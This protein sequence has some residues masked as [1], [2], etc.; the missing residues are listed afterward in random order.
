MINSRFTLTRFSSSFSN[1]RNTEAGKCI[2]SIGLPCLLGKL[3]DNPQ[4]ASWFSFLWSSSLS[5]FISNRMALLA[6]L[7]KLGGSLLAGSSCSLSPW[8]CGTSSSI[9]K[10]LLTGWIELTEASSASSPSCSLSSWKLISRNLS[11][12]ILNRLLVSLEH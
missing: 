2:H 10:A 5:H 12:Y 3:V 1:R 11:S 8:S 7:I 4:V 6:G 9:G